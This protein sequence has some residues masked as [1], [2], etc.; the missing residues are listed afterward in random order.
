MMS[1]M[2]NELI[3][4]I[5]PVYNVEEYLRKCLDSIIS[6]TYINLEIILVD[7]GSPDNCPVIC[8]EYA[9]KDSR[10]KVIHK[11]NGGLS[12]ARNAG[13]KI[14]SGEYITYIDSDDYV[15][16]QFIEFLSNGLNVDTCGKTVDIVVENSYDNSETTEMENKYS[17]LSPS[18]ALAQMLC[19][20]TFGVSAWAKLYSRRIAVKY[21]FPKG[22]IYEDFATTYKMFGDSECI[23]HCSA[24]HYHYV[25]RNGSICNSEW[26]D[27]V[28]YITEAAEDML[29]YIDEFYP[30][31]HYYGVYGYF[32]AANAFMNRAYA[33]SDFKN[34]VLPVRKRLK[35]LLPD[36]REKSSII[37]KDYFKFFLM[38]YLPE[39]KI[40]IA[41]L[42]MRFE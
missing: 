14:A 17:V 18:D 25:I 28:Y 27:G 1:E 12:D 8:D 15:D 37:S 16:E 42:K 21:P 39:L 7:D 31:I 20:K 29:D 22:K 24:I 19:E 10:I 35:E 4:V 6:Q 5:V 40:R 23:V 9:A 3:S 34:K 11:E 38:A 41:D 13:T 26:N 36:I 32:L 30:E 33:S 2:R